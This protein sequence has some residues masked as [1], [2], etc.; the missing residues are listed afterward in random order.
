MSTRKIWNKTKEHGFIFWLFKDFLCSFWKLFIPWSTDSFPSLYD[1]THWACLY[2]LAGPLG[3]MTSSDVSSIQGGK[4]I[5]VLQPFFSSTYLAPNVF[6]PSPG[7]HDEQVI[8]GQ[9]SPRKTKILCTGKGNSIPE[10]SWITP[11]K[12][13]DWTGVDVLSFLLGAL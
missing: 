8:H 11:V 9:H 12:R 10:D 1:R 5:P 4:N 7:W 3:A 13:A 6:M 2:I